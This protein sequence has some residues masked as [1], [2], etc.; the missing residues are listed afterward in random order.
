MSGYFR[1]HDVL[2]K[3]SAL[4]STSATLVKISQHLS[5]N[6]NEITYLCHLKKVIARP[7][8]CLQVKNNDDMCTKTNK[9]L[10]VNGKCH[11]KYFSSIFFPL[12][13]FKVVHA[14]SVYKIVGDHECDLWYSWNSWSNEL[15]L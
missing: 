1:N 15:V 12:H 13:V 14:H 6:Q 9:H 4:I 2:E 8:I 11:R 5:S 3:T 7:D 10:F